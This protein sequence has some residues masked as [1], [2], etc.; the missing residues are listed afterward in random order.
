MSSRVQFVRQTADFGL[1]LGMLPGCA[2]AQ[3]Q[4]RDSFAVAWSG[5]LIQIENK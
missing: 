5:D 2:A 1:I 4:G 3:D